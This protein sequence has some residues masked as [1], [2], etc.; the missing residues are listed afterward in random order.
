[1]SPERRKT[2]R[3]DGTR[4]SGKAHRSPNGEYELLVAEGHL[5]GR[6][7]EEGA[8]R[9][10]S[11]VFAF[12]NGTICF[13]FD[14]GRPVYGA[15]ANNGTAIVVE[16]P[17]VHQGETSGC[18]ISV[19][20]QEEKILLSEEVEGFV[21]AAIDHRGNNIAL[22]TGSDVLI[23]GV[24]NSSLETWHES[25]S[26]VFELEFREENPSLIDIHDDY[27]SPVVYTIN[28][29][30]EIVESVDRAAE[31]VEHDIEN[32]IELIETEDGEELVIAWNNLY[33][34][35]DSE[36]NIIDSAHVP[37]LL[38]SIKRAELLALDTEEYAPRVAPG[39]NDEIR[40]GWPKPVRM[41][42]SRIANERPAELIP[43]ADT[44]VEMLGDGR[45][46]ITSTAGWSLWTLFKESERQMDTHELD[47][48]VPAVES[49]L[50]SDDALVREQA[51]Q[52]QKGIQTAKRWGHEYEYSES[53]G[54]GETP[55]VKSG[56]R[57]QIDRVKTG[58]DPAEI[59]AACQVIQTGFK[60]ECLVP[61]EHTDL[62]PPLLQ[63]LAE[64]EPD[65][66]E[67]P[68]TWPDYW[69]S[70]R[71]ALIILAELA[72]H[73][74]QAFAGSFDRLI[75]YAE[76]ATSKN[77]HI[78]IFDIFI[79]IMDADSDFFTSEISPYH[80][81]IFAEIEDSINQI[82][83]GPRFC[84]AYAGINPAALGPVLPLL[85][86]H[87]NNDDVYAALQSVATNAPKALQEHDNLLLT[88]LTAGQRVVQRRSAGILSSLAETGNFPVSTL[89]NLITS[90]NTGVY[91][92]KQEREVLS[93]VAAGAEA[94]NYLPQQVWDSLEEVANSDDWQVREAVARIAVS[95]E[96][97]QRESLLD[98]LREDPIPQVQ[99]VV[100]D[101]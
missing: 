61:S 52:A 99:D 8:S 97:P 64:H 101:N 3:R 16:G 21:D 82:D 9:V 98:R 68:D 17:E 77:A 62:I 72:P 67:D 14:A 63:F 76:T 2:I 5:D 49:L 23:L 36:P 37:R 51:S 84:Q 86:Q 27:D 10:K 73:N 89:S 94:D 95:S 91:S 58:N 88:E 60:E 1:M 75:R 100:R 50:D 7:D 48:Y 66:L 4:Y 70:K 81:D 87:L 57:A 12:Q 55:S 6:A 69:F 44:L 43:H 79:K 93:I 30:G 18:S 15:I 46:I 40:Q 59:I 28:L 29:Q 74:P 92:S 35:V 19:I 25:D 54:G 31:R 41:T 33:D 42:F 45:E 47:Q 26:T 32:L 65:N 80:D 11:G 22:S 13:E 34:A 39:K 38:D 78:A 90:L 20:D 85:I 24:D 56:M 96:N 71:A 53:N 83:S